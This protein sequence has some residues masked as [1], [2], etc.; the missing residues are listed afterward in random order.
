MH[1]RINVARR[2]L[3]IIDTTIMLLS[4]R[5]L[6]TQDNTVAS[7][8]LR[9][10]KQR[11]LPNLLVPGCIAKDCRELPRLIEEIIASVD[12]DPSA[13]ASG[14]EVQRLR[15]KIA[16]SVSCRSAIKINTPLSDKKMRW[17]VDELFRCENPYTCPHGR[18]ITLRINI[19]DVLR[20]FKRI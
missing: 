8:R 18:P 10:A 7:H 3:S 11:A 1:S 14:A 20:G 16:I 19:E 2:S 13:P 5:N 6:G 15:E 17:L 4:R 12:V 9:S